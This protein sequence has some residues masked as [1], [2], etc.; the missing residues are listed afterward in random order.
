MQ[1]L[2]AY[3]MARQVRRAR[4]RKKAQLIMRLLTA[5]FSAMVLKTMAMKQYRRATATLR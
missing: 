2:A 1:M 4:A 5:E 3:L